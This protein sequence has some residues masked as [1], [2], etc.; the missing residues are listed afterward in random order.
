[1]RNE[2][3]ASFLLAGVLLLL[4]AG[5]YITVSEMG[6]NET[7]QNA[8]NVSAPIAE[9]TNFSVTVPVVQNVPENLTE[10]NQTAAE[11]ANATNETVA[12]ANTIDNTTRSNNTYIYND[13]NP[14]SNG[15]GNG[16]GSGNNNN[17]RTIT[18][19]NSSGG[20]LHYGDCLAISSGRVCLEDVAT[21]DPYEAILGVYDSSNRKVSTIM[22]APSF[23]SDKTVSLGNGRA[24]YVKVYETAINGTDVQAVVYISNSNVDSGPTLSDG[25][26]Y[27]GDCVKL[28][29]T[30]VCLDMIS[31][32]DPYHAQ[33]NTYDSQDRLIYSSPAYAGDPITIDVGN[34]KAVSILVSQ[35]VSS[36]SSE[37]VIASIKSI[38]ADFNALLMFCGDGRFTQHGKISLEDVAVSRPYEAIFEVVNRNDERDRTNI[39]VKPGSYETAEIDDGA[40][41]ISIHVYKTVQNGTLCWALVSMSETDLT[42]STATATLNFDECVDAGFAKACLADMAMDVPHNAI[43]AVYDGDGNFVSNVMVAPGGSKLVSVDDSTDARIS[44]S[45]TD[46]IYDMSGFSTASAVVSISRG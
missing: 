31:H 46:F 24:I 41:E 34:G 44:V 45:E 42:S 27:I 28:E 5:G 26:M 16:G 40:K 13:T 18:G 10:T 1:M 30:S 6:A 2:V 29:F 21:K 43:L 37:W 11:T 3:M 25:R 33:F 20:L 17:R 39:M 7:A 32:G 12:V 38:N 36:N 23:G 22:V 14:Y 19:T 15:G 35:I 8:T 9:T 4:G